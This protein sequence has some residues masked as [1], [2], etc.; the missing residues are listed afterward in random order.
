MWKIPYDPH[1]AL[2]CPEPVEGYTLHLSDII[3]SDHA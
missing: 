1:S 3:M 2:P